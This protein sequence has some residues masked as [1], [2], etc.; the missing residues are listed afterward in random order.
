MSVI[1]TA[2][3][4]FD[5]SPIELLFAYF[6]RGEINPENL[7][8]AKKSKLPIESKLFVDTIGAWLSWYKPVLDKLTKDLASCFGIRRAL[9]CSSI[10]C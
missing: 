1:I 8:T 2:P 10:L 5:S 3:Y 6:K 4:S 9:N 7:S